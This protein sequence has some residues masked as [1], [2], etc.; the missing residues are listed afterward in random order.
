MRAAGMRLLRPPASAVVIAVPAAAPL[1]EGAEPGMPPHVTL[2]W[3]FARRIRAGHRRGLAAI[4]ERHQEFEFT[5]ARVGEFTGVVYFAPEPAAPFVEL[6]HAIADTWP[7][8]QPYAGAYPDVIPHVT[9][10]LGGASLTDAERARLEAQLPIRCH[11]TE[12]LLLAPD[13]GGWRED[14]RVPLTSA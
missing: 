2:L 1:V 10:R 14:Y 4:A 6:I 11:A 8:H 12:I 9:V 7:R 13:G 5:L 3:P